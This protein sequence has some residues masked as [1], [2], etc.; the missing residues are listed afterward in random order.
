MTATLTPARF[1]LA[2]PSTVADFFEVLR[3]VG[4]IASVQ[5]NGV[6]VHLNSGGGDVL[7]LLAEM[8]YERNQF[9]AF[10]ADT[11]YWRP[12]Y[13][14]HFGPLTEAPGDQWS[15]LVPLTADLHAL[16]GYITGAG[17][18]PDT[19][20]GEPTMPVTVYAEDAEDLY[21]TRRDLE[22]EMNSWFGQTMTL[23]PV[24]D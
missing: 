8:L 3:S 2:L 16:L 12:S 4:T 24:E 6:T 7:R 5:Q 1:T 15:T 9:P 14:W 17:S 19:Y 21:E 20:L 22:D 10:P 11:T 13:A 18:Y 23:V